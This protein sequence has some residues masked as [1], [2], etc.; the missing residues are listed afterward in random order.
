MEISTFFQ[1]SFGF[2]KE[3][4]DSLE[5]SGYFNNVEICSFRKKEIIIREGDQ[6]DNMFFLIKG[7]VRWFFLDDNG[8]ELTDDL[9]YGFGETA[10]PYFYSSMP[11]MVD[12]QAITNVQ[13][14]KVPRLS[15]DY[16]MDHYPELLRKS[17][18]II[19]EKYLQHW[20]FRVKILPQNSMERYEWFIR[21]H[22]ALIGRIS[23]KYIASFL[24]MTP[25][26]LSRVQKRYR[27]MHE[28]ESSE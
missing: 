21:N 1:K 4:L 7:V 13:M 3:T 22:G 23:N 15:F 20:Q 6:L 14:V 9:V 28:N 27:E 24:A 19:S 5:Q 16:M 10:I 11:S 25:S 26:T 2:S 12:I 18:R 8:N 17:V